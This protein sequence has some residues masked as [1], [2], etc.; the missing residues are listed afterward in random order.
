MNSIVLFCSCVPLHSSYTQN[1]CADGQTEAIPIIP[2]PFCGR[3]LTIYKIFGPG[4]YIKIIWDAIHYPR[5]VWNVSNKFINIKNV[6]FRM[7]NI[8][9]WYCQWY[10][11]FQ[12]C[13]LGFIF[14]SGTDHGTE[15]SLNHGVMFKVAN[16]GGIYLWFC[17]IFLS[18]YG[19]HYAYK[20]KIWQFDRRL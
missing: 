17:P 14:V 4:N 19:L 15:L 20:C 10:V 6:I 3:G 8:K 9:S 13:S 11:P 12:N 1:V 18:F 5:S 7:T 2:S 16:L